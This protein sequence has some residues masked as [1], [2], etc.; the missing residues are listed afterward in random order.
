M[1]EI[2]KKNKNMT[3]TSQDTSD[4]KIKEVYIKTEDTN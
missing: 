4:V 3:F 2:D 1:D